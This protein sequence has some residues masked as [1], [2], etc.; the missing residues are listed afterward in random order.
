[1]ITYAEDEHKS[2]AGCNRM[3]GNVTPMDPDF[4]QPL[5]H[6]VSKKLCMVSGGLRSTVR[7]QTVQYG[8]LSHPRLH[9]VHLRHR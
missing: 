1:M 2:N 7:R 3:L 6:K 9:N 4:G 5:W 8:S